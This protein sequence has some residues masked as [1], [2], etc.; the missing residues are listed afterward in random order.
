MTL[1]SKLPAVWQTHWDELGFDTP[2]LIQEKSFDTL[3]SKESLV[4]ISPTGSG[5]TLAYLWPLLTA[6]EPG[7]GNQLLILLPSQELAVQV[8]AVTK[9]WAD[10]IGIK[11]ES[12]IGGANVKRQVE[13][14]KNKPEVLVGTPGRIWELIKIKKVKAHLLKT[15]VLDEVDQLVETSE[16]NAT[17][18][19]MKAVDRQIQ[20]VCVSATAVALDEKLGA[21][22]KND[23]M[24]L[25]VTDEDQSAGEVIHGF[26]KTTPRKRVE[27]LRK[28]AYVTD[29]KGII[30]FNEV[31]EMGFVADK[32][33]FNGVPNVTLASDQNKMERKLALSAFAD[34]KVNLLLTTD[35]GARGLDFDALP[36]VIHYDVPYR[37]ENYVHRSGRTGR[38]GNDGA[39]ISMVSDFEL[40][41]LKKMVRQKDWELK[42]LMVHS[43]QILPVSDHQGQISEASFSSQS[44]NH[45]EEL[46]HVYHS[47]NLV[48]KKKK[49]KTKKKSPSKKKKKKSQ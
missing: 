23:L 30:F 22:G 37:L 32:L 29:F 40:V 33:A 10:L 43:Q 19:I 27:L 28:L 6:V 36:Y 13:K 2:S 11:S 31:Q 45:K 21:L 8:A 49:V 48:I 7:Q 35:L 18:H 25:D 9:E 12:L 5:K 41:E 14:L 47:E 20:L 39:V 1:K 4:G 26:F 44:K 24:T 42:E 3:V 17:K 15:L 34:N 38:M 16:L 46:A